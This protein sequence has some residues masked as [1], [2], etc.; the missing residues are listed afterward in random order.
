VDAPGYTRARWRVTV[1]E[2]RRTVGF[3]AEPGG[4]LTITV[5]RDTDAAEVVAAVTVRLP[6]MARTANRQAEIAPG[7]P[8]KEIVDGENFP[9]LGRPRRLVLTEEADEDV[10]L[11]GDR[12]IAVS[13]QR[14]GW[15][16]R[17]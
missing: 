1:S 7:H 8:L 4:A 3:T 2:R 10:Q 12:L 11:V 6:W 17:L 16:H 5:P 15:P 14:T 9:Y 13:D